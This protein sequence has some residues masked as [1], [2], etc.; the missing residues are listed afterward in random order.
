MDKCKECPECGCARYEQKNNLGEGYRVCSD[1]GQEWYTTINYRKYSSPAY[2]Y[3]VF[4][5]LGRSL[6]PKDRRGDASPFDK[7]SVR[8][9]V[10]NLLRH[11]MTV[12]A[13]VTKP[14]EKR[15][16]IFSNWGP[17]GFVDLIN[18]NANRIDRL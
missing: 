15:R 3:E 16:L 4:T 5:S 13:F 9:R 14:N 11:E 17:S 7:R 18:V 12:T 8:R 2:F 6:P 10:R 1:C